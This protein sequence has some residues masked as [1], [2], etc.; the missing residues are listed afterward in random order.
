MVRVCCDWCECAESDVGG[1]EVAGKAVE[2]GGDRGG[3]EV[4]T[5]E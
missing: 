5:G 3:V 1:V 4:G 2:E